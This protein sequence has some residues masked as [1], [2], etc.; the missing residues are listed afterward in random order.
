VEPASRQF[1]ARLGVLL[2]LLLLPAAAHGLLPHAPECVSRR[3]LALPCPGCG[4]G[5]ALSA[6]ADLELAAA[7]AH[8][9]PILPLALAYLA[10]VGASAA[11][12]CSR[13]LPGRQR[14][15]TALGW[16]VALSVA[17]TWIVRLVDSWT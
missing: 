12:L 9:P 1:W 10:A 13:P 2:G 16:G 8:Y 15:G 5:R 7:I 17:G 6:A 11:W 14:V 3:L 4:L